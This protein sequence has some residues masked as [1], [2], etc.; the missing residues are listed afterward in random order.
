M[1]LVLTSFPQRDF[2]LPFGCFNPHN[3]S[4]ITSCYLT[5]LESYRPFNMDAIPLLGGPKVS[6]EKVKVQ[7]IHVLESQIPDH[8]KT[9]AVDLPKPKLDYK[10]NQSLQEFRRVANYIAAGTSTLQLRRQF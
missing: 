4:S 5:A 8:V 7:N 1:G 9:L 2:Q 10:T 3:A 6:G